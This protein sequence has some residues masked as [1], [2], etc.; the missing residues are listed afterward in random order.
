MQT[1]K[2]GVFASQKGAA[3]NPAV[4]DEV[5]P[6]S[7]SDRRPDSTSKRTCDE[8]SET[9]LKDLFEHGKA[10]DFSSFQGIYKELAK[11]QLCS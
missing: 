8:L 6:E 10:N 5:P 9:E 1:I 11:Q 4:T 3:A 2:A 7:H